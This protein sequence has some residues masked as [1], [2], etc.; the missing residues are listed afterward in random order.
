M[1]SMKKSI[2]A[3]AASAIA[4]GLSACG[5]SNNASSSTASSGT[6][7][8]S[9]G[10]VSTEGIKVAYAS[11]LDPNDVADQFGL[12]AAKAKVQTLNDDSAVIAGLQ[13]GSIDVGNVD[14]DQAA[15]AVAK[16]MPIKIIYAAQTTPE[17]VLVGNPSVAT[18]NDL[19]G[20][21][22]G[23]QGPGSQTEIFVK[24]I[25]KQ[26]VPSIAGKVQFISLAESSRRAQA[27]VAN[28]LD[29]SSLES[30][31]YAQLKKQG[32][33]HLLS[34]WSDL[35]G[36]AGQAIGTAWITT[37]AEYAKDGKRLTAF[38][39]DLQRGYNETYN[40][41]DAWVALAKKTLPDVDA[42]LFPAVYDVYISRKMYPQAGTPTLTPAVWSANEKFWRG[43][44]E[45]S[46]PLDSSLIAFDLVQAGAA[47]TATTTAG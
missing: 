12:Q 22:V 23:Y 37:D 29:V 8:A 30:I 5:G 21:K 9:S 18:L 16:G 41:K 13:R 7:S 27:M 20:K 28:H 10:A 38:V 11:A 31:N 33:Y 46:K 36:G 47:E 15:A 14:F 3:V 6:A 25:V 26:K 1:D 32:N 40:N 45:W 44:G 24:N 35:A 4:I 34:S 19:A 39:K 43:I 17:Y 2:A 42:S